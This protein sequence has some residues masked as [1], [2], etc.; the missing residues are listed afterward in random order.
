MGKFKESDYYKSKEHIENVKKVS[1]LGNKKIQELKEQRIKNYNLSPK[2]CNYCESSL[3]YEDRHKSYCNS[4]CASKYNNSKRI[5]SKETKEQIKTSLLEY[6]DANPSK[7]KKVIDEI[8]TCEICSSDFQVKRIPSGGISRSKTC[9]K[10]CTYKK[11]SITS[12]KT[13]KKVIDSGKHKGWQCRN[14]V[15]YPENFFMGVLEDVGLG[16]EYEFNYPINK[17]VDLGI[18][19][20]YNY[21]LDFYF[22]KKRL[23]LEIDGSQHKHRVEHD[24]IRDQRLSTIGIYTYRIKWKSINTKNGKEYIK[25]QIDNFLNFYN[26]HI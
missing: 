1:V 8:R 11:K 26:C 19:E 24:M 16:D 21:F 10:E 14:A 3:S 15:S 12:K 9:S 5:L 25:K 13:M 17:K 22:P 2:V 7:K 20:P 23:V 6:Y 18:D 4:S